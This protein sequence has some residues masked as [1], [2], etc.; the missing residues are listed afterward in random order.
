MANHCYSDLTVSGPAGD[1]KAF[2]AKMET[3]ESILDFSQ[4]SEEG[5]AFDIKRN[6]GVDSVVYEYWTKWGPVEYEADMIA[7]LFPTL[8][9]HYGYG[10]IGM[11]FCGYRVFKNGEQIDEFRSSWM[12]EMEKVSPS[13]SVEEQEEDW[14]AFDRWL[15]SFGSMVPPSCSWEMYLARMADELRP[16]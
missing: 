13:P 6:A 14:D 15:N 12:A 3:K 16:V 5:W 1:I 11:D 4:F 7:E 2:V 8:T 10:E 9:F